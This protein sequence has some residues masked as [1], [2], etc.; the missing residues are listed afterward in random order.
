MDTDADK[1]SYEELSRA[2][3]E[4]RTAYRELAVLSYSVAHDLRA[5]L[6]KIGG[7]SQILL[8]DHSAQMSAECKEYR[9]GVRAAGHTMS[10]LLEALMKLVSLARAQIRRVDVDLN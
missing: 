1:P 8:D 4:S 2:L 10:Q 7:Y 6:R 3:E 9:R 5:P